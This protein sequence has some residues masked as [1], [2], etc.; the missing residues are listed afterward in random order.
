M[1]S[2]PCL[3]VQGVFFHLDHPCLERHEELVG[4]IR[5]HAKIGKMSEVNDTVDGTNEASSWVAAFSA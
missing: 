2:F 3:G 5:Q 4:L 1:K